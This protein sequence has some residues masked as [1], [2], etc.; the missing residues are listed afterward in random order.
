MPNMAKIVFIRMGVLFFLCVG[1][2]FY[3]SSNSGDSLAIETLALRKNAQKL[4]A[5]LPIPNADVT[6]L[7]I[8]ARV[9][10]LPPDSR[11]VNAMDHLRVDDG[12]P[13]EMPPKLLRNNKVEV[14]V[15]GRGGEFYVHFI[16]EPAKS[17]E[18]VQYAVCE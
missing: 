6:K 14:R 7:M 5:S 1:A 11:F 17:C 15:I 10:T 18:N 16:G 8:A 9:A 13:K 3:E 12:F 2:Y 4:F